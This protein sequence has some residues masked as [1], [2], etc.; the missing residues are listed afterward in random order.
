[1]PN[2]LLRHIHKKRFSVFF[3]HLQSKF[4]KS[5]YKS[6]YSIQFNSIWLSINA[7]FHADFESVEKVLKKC[8]KKVIIKNVTEICTFSLLLMFVKLVLLITFLCL[9]QLFQRIR[10][11]RK[12]LRFLI[13]FFLQ[14]K[15][16]WGSY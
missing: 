7:E 2:K 8:T 11:Q 15:K 6:Q 10:N 3:E 4:T 13:Y 14:K 1:M 5:A 16:F 12:I 9:F